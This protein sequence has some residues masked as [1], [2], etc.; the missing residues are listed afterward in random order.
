[1]AASDNPAGRLHNLLEKYLAAKQANPGLSVS[2]IW[3]I[4]LE[5]K[6][7]DETLIA[8][9]RV[10]SLIPDISSAARLYGS[11][12]GDTSAVDAVNLYL[13]DWL[14]PLTLPSAGA[15]RGLARGTGEISSAAMTALA[16]V[17][18]TLSLW[19]PQ[20]SDLEPD[21]RAKIRDA[22]ETV[23][24]LVRQDDDLPK[25]LKL[26][27]LERLY[28]LLQ[29]FNDFDISGVEGVARACD[30][31]A[32]ALAVDPRFA[33]AGGKEWKS[34]AKNIVSRVLSAIGVLDKASGA[35][36]LVERGMRALEG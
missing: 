19:M 36:D 20:G 7:D 26:M 32:V 34:K 12:T 22:V 31:L 6:S 17:S 29:A 35:F 14:V 25:E 21:Y 5:L 1:M 30:R 11:E 2:K 27:M 28:S 9:L 18:T 3:R 33:Q 15:D 4:C 23:I 8:V 16:S 24:R 13:A 10:A